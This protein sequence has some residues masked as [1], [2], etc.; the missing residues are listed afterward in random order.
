MNNYYSKK[1]KEMTI[2]DLEKLLNGDLRDRVSAVNFNYRLD[3]L[4]N[5]PESTVRFAVASEGYGLDKLIDDPDPCVRSQVA[6]KGYGLDRLINDLSAYVR[7]EV[8]N[9]GYGLDKLIN[10]PNSDVRLVVANRKYGL[11]I[12]RHDITIDVSNAALYIIMDESIDTSE[13]DGCI[14][15]LL[16]NS[17]I[18]H[19]DAKIAFLPWGF[20]TKDSRS[21]YT[22]FY[23]Y[24]VRHSDD[25]DDDPCT[26]EDKVSVNRWVSIVTD[27]PLDLSD[28]TD[29]DRYMNIP[30]DLKNDFRDVYYDFNMK[31]ADITRRIPNLFTY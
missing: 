12:L 2:S 25:S 18:S 4:I 28:G 19:N 20:N 10:D 15:D 3:I 31:W 27:K 14:K 26:I 5:D 7:A 1:L 23:F 11:E 8:A 9:K 16:I 29:T 21:K 17:S 22:D 6:N 24:D 13:I 30:M